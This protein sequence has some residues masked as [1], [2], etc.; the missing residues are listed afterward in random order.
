M[1]QYNF[2]SVVLI[3]LFSIILFICCDDFSLY[4]LTGGPTLNPESVT[5]YFSE[6]CEFSALNGDEPYLF[7]VQ[8]GL[9]SIDPDTGLYTAPVS[10]S[11]DTVMVTDSGGKTDTASVKVIMELVIFPESIIIFENTHHVFTADGGVLPYIFS[12]LSGN[13]TVNSSTGLY[14]APDT[15]GNAVLRV[16]DSEGNISDANIEIVASDA[17]IINPPEAVISSGEKVTLTAY[18][19]SGPAYTFSLESASAMLTGTSLTDIPPDS[20]EFSS[21]GFGVAVICVTDSGTGIAYAEIT[22]NSGIPLA[23]SPHDITIDISSTFIFTAAGGQPPYSFY[24]ES[25][26][27]TINSVTGL[28]TAP[29]Y[30]DNNIWVGVEDV[31]GSTDT[32]RIKVKDLK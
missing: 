5:L 28:Y 12:V 19:L 31:L 23:I 9:G 24:M 14:T 2:Y 7:S 22:V 32:A 25:G 3:L 15:P 11:N 30:K 4:D 20:A 26:P 29:D 21:S 13:G 17:L 6:T 18:S 10:E 16:T 1:E 27:G 8:S